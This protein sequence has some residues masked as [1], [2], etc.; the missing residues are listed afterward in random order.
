MAHEQRGHVRFSTG[1]WPHDQEGGP[2]HF[3]ADGPHCAVLPPKGH[4]PQGPGAREH[5]F[6]AELNV[7]LTDLASAT[8]QSAPSWAH[9]VAASLMLPQSSFWTKSVMALWQKCGPWGW[10]CIR[11]RALLGASAEDTKQPLPC[12]LF[13]VFGVWKPLKKINY[14]WP[15][16]QKNSGTRKDLWLNAGQEGELRPCS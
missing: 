7:K 14:P 15:Q 5:G 10:F 3:P 11:W 2:R 8:S 16:W 4:H 1:P 9:S 12:P 13:H 6:D